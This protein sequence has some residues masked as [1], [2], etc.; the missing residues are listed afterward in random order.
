[1]QQKESQTQYEMKMTTNNIDLCI[2]Y[3]TLIIHTCLWDCHQKLQPM[4]TS[5]VTMI[6]M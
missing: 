2:Y 3:S 4:I 6:D 5:Y 1:M